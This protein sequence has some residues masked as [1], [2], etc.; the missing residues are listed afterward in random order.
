MTD[1]NSALLLWPLL[2]VWST[3]FGQTLA[4]TLNC[5]KQR[6][7]MFQVNRQ[8]VADARGVSLPIRPELCPIL[9]V[10]QG[11]RTRRRA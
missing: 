5:T 11:L 3:P 8:I 9:K 10:C 4:L 7:G 1:L 6:P 2:I